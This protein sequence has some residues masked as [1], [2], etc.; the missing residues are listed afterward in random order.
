MVPVDSDFDIVITSNAGYPLDL[1]IYQSVKGMSAAS[2]I[3]REGGSILL[4]AECWDGIPDH[5][6]YA[7]LMK[8]TTSIENLLEHLHQPG[9]SQRDSWQG[10][11]QGQILL[12]ADIY[13]H[14]HLLDDET[15]RSVK[16]RPA[17]SLQKTLDDLLDH[18]GPQARICVMPEGP[19]TIPYI[20]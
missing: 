9:Y 4:V 14:S 19:L 6:E 13:L 2:Q 10:Q 16:L 5:G 15:I 3:T 18:Y 7:R 8:E 17:A 11:I 20:Q 12:N 1:N